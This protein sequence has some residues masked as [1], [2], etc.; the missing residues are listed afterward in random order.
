MS[1]TPVRGAGDKTDAFINNRREIPALRSPENAFP[2]DENAPTGMPQ[3]S[4]S[5]F[6]AP[7]G[8]GDFIDPE[9]RPRRWPFEQGAAMTVPE[10]SVHEKAD[11]V[12]GKY[13]IGP[14]R[15]VAAMQAKT[16]ATGVQGATQ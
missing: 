7:A 11:S 6:I 15:Q 16:Q 5:L 10:A 12:A 8:G 3:P 4:D 14:S 1:R 2:D 13:E 9:N